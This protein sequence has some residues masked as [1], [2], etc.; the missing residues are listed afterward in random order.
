M[1]N[2]NLLRSIDEVHRASLIAGKNWR[3]VGTRRLRPSSP[4]SKSSC[5]PKSHSKTRLVSLIN[6]VKVNL[7][8]YS[9]WLLPAPTRAVFH[10][11][12]YR[13]QSVRTLPTLQFTLSSIT[14]EN[15]YR[16]TARPHFTQLAPP[17][18]NR[19]AGLSTGLHFTYNFPISH[20]YYVVLRLMWMLV[21]SSNAG[22]AVSPHFT[23]LCAVSHHYHIVKL[24]YSVKVRTLPTSLQSDTTIVKF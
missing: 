18:H 11:A 16:Q 12:F 21:R 9:P 24:L 19:S 23:Q 5:G 20:H 3:I 2:C 13:L 1:T 22:A 4:T 8:H 15:C 6:Y 17:S 10:L 14:L 7:R